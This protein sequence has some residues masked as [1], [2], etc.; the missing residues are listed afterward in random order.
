[1]WGGT[2]R[3]RMLAALISALHVLALGIGL[4]SI[5]ARG[6]AL[7]AVAAGEA[8]AV[9]RVLFA[10]NFWGAAALLWIVTGLTRAFAGLE[11]GRDFYLYNGLFWVKMALFALVFALEIAPMV[12]FI[13]W[14]RVI[15]KGGHPNTTSAARFARLSDLETVLVVAIPFVAAAM[16]RGLWLLG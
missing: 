4:G 15:A 14:R 7:R 10:D 1:M 3:A 16:S 8:S 9:A 11:K 13:G 2:L 12:A 5:F 6:R